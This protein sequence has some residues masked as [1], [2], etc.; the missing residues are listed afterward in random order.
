MLEDVVS[1]LADRVGHL[2]EEGGRRRS[3]VCDGAAAPAPTRQQPRP[4]APPGSPSKDSARPPRRTSVVR[5]GAPDSERLGPRPRRGDPA[6]GCRRGRCGGR[7]GQRRRGCGPAPQRLRRP[8][9]R[10]AAPAPTGRLD[11]AAG[12]RVQRRQSTL[13]SSASGRRASRLA[14]RSSPEAATRLPWRGGHLVA[15]PRRGQ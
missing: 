5:G 8:R 11:V 3:A 12:R 2:G 4:T 6:V 9:R 15:D 10:P 1:Q 13:R 14:T 7:E